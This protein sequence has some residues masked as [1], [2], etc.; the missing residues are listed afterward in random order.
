MNEYA[1]RR[2]VI[3]DAL[4][5][6]DGPVLANN[7]IS[8]LLGVN[9]LVVRRVRRNL[10]ALGAIPKVYRRMSRRGYLIDV[11]RMTETHIAQGG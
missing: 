5:T 11:S 6:A 2:T 4:R 9:V 7:E 3:E 1:R 8:R 10:E